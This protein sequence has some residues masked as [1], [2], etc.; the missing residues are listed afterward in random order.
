[1]SRKRGAPCAEHGAVAIVPLRKTPTVERGDHRSAV[2]REFGIGVR[3]VARVQLHRRPDDA[4][5]PF[6]ALA[7]ACAVP[8]AA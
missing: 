4:R 3:G 8:L 6:A 2:E 5:P 7:R 1:M